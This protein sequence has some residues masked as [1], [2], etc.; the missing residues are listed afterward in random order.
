MPASNR[1]P[2]M[3]AV[4]GGWHSPNLCVIKESKDK[5][6]K[7]RTAATGG[8]LGHIKI[9]IWLYVKL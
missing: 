9:C 6:S 3:R 5:T 2:S 4:F 7:T 8:A 1:Q